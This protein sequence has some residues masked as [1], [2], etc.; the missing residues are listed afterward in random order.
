MLLRHVGLQGKAA[1][2]E[3]A[4]RVTLES[5][6]HTADFGTPG[7][8]VSSTAEF[9]RAIVSNF[10]ARPSNEAV[11]GSDSAY[12]PTSGHSGQNR[13]LESQSVSQKPHGIDLFVESNLQP[14]Q[15]AD[16]IQPLLGGGIQLTLI[17]NRGTQVW[18]TGSVLTDCVNQY[19]V[20]IEHSGERVLSERELLEVALRVAHHMRVC[21]TELL[22]VYDG[23]PGFSLAQGQ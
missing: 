22:M 10:H 9:A 3:N 4:L 5:G 2:I 12:V 16:I 20:R 15:I 11:E 8:P 17:S 23:V 7:T 1:L 19:R 21:S 13:M 14:T 6:A 18:P